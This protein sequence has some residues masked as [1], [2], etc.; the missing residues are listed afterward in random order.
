VEALGT[1]LAGVID[2]SKEQAVLASEIQKRRGTKLE[3]VAEDA[4]VVETG[5]EITERNTFTQFECPEYRL[6][7]YIDGFQDGKVVETKNRKR[8]WSIPPAYDFVQL[9]CY[10]RMKGRV[11]GVLLENFPAKA[12]RTTMVPW[13]EEMW[14]SI[15][16]GLCEVS[17][18]IARMSEADVVELTRTVYAQ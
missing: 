17:A 3:K 5:K 8:F 13:E 2:A 7:G 18:D 16:S 11:P 14:E 4:F 1:V 6:I 12:P 9:R 15:H 10:M